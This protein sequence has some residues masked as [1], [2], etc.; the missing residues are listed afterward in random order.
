[1][2]IIT[3]SLAVTTAG[4]DAAAVGSG[5]MDGVRG[6]LL[7]VWLD[8]HADAPATTDVT[9]AYT[10]RGG[11]IAAVTNNATDILIAP[12]Q[13]PAVDLYPIDQGLT[14]SVAGSNAL[15]ACVTAWFRILL[16]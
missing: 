6:F 1:M 2:R 13:T 3:R 14:L 10:T 9:L 15:T 4:D 7:D 5:E 12:R 8:Y 11:S 16:V